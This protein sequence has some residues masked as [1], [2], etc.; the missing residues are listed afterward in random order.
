MNPFERRFRILN[1]YMKKIE[2]KRPPK[3]E[4]VQHMSNLCKEM[5]EADMCIFWLYD[6]TTNKI[7]S[8]LSSGIDYEIDGLRGIIGHVIESGEARLVASNKEDPYY[9]KEMDEI[10]G[11]VSKS[12]IYVPMKHSNNNPYGAIHI[13]DRNK[14]FSFDQED[15]ETMVFIGLYAEEALT[16]YDFEDELL[17]T[18]DDIIFLLA[19]I[20]EKR[21]LETSKHARRV[22]YMVEKMAKLA[23]LPDNEVFLL[24]M[25]SPLHDIGKV[26][27]E[28]SIL[29][30]P[31][32]LTEEEYDKIKEHSSIGHSILS[33]IKR[34]LL[35]VAD[36]V[37][38]EHHERFDGKGYPL[39]IKGEDIHIYARITTVCDVFDALANE[40]PY[41]KAWE[42]EKIIEEFKRQRG[43]QF[44]P[45]LTDLFLENIDDFYSILEKHKDLE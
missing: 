25:A 9:D 23:G 33:P 41:K 27:V 36:I 26:G 14:E 21:S 12:S 29:N 42:K 11:F 39:G 6:E 43:K 37:A 34:R 7:Y 44:D 19:E 16:S 8:H 1:K 15:L 17:R 40:R 18:Q 5:M 3:D 28:D 13:V 2:R 30:K 22:S 35:K 4:Y 24:K 20:G 45:L 38:Y 32:R 31:G 10:L